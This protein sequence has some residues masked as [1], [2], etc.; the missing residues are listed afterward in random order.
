MYFF[1]LVSYNG[2]AYHGVNIQY[3]RHTV[4][5]IIEYCLNSVFKQNIRAYFISRTDKGVSAINQYFYFNYKFK[6]ICEQEF[7]L[8]RLSIKIKNYSNYNIIMH[9]YYAQDNL[10]LR[11]CNKEY[12]YRLIN[13][14]NA[15]FKDMCY[16]HN[17]NH[18]EMNMF[19]NILQFLNNNK[20]DYSLFCKQQHLNN[21]P[22]IQVLNIRYIFDSMYHN[23]E[24]MYIII[25]GMCFMYRQIRLLIGTIINICKKCDL[26][27]YEYN[28]HYIMNDN[29]MLLKYKHSAP[30]YAL[31]LNKI[32]LDFS[33][34]VRTE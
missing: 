12:I 2:S 9:G 22:N 8:N 18:C 29:N 14:Y 31:L 28:P 30:S 4:A 11:H 3:N 7:K 33:S 24:I 1:C 32:M 17:F 6:D 5:S 27:K 34:F 15:S 10:C 13:C 25:Q 20:F 21:R 26:L 16:A 23:V 19:I